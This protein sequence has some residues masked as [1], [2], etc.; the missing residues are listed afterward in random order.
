MVQISYFESQAVRSRGCRSAKPKTIAFALSLYSVL[1]Q[2]SFW[3]VLLF[4]K[5]RESITSTIQKCC[6]IWIVLS[7]LFERY[8]KRKKSASKWGNNMSAKLKLRSRECR[9]V[10]WDVFHLHSLL[11][12]LSASLP[13]LAND[14][15]FSNKFHALYRCFLFVVLD[16]FLNWNS[17][18]I[19]AQKHLSNFNSQ[20]ERVSEQDCLRL[21]PLRT[22]VDLWSTFVVIRVVSS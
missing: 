13:R 19:P 5:I 10:K 21:V 6:N 20:K 18:H 1:Y 15:A 11:R 3:L 14:T 9:A 2:G 7:E 12:S 4:L 8:W 22:E 17:F 16:G